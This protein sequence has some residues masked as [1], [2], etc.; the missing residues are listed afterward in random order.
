[1][2]PKYKVTVSTNTVS[3]ADIS[4]SSD[5]EAYG[6]KCFDSDVSHDK[7]AVRYC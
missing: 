6:V 4:F 1:M 5:C 3:C 2:V 7:Q